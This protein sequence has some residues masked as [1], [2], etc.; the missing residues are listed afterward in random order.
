MENKLLSIF[1]EFQWID[2]EDLRKKCISTW[3]Q[4]IAE[5]GWNEESLLKLPF[6]MTELKDCPVLLVEHVKNVTKTAKEI[7]ELFIERYDIPQ[8]PQ[9]DV[10]I[11]GA[12]LHDVGKLIE[13]E[14]ADGQYRHCR[15]GD[16]IRHPLAGAIIAAQNGLPDEIIHIVG[17]HSFEGDHSYKT[18][19]SYIVKTSDWLNFNYLS[20]TYPN[21]MTH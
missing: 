13:Y 8:K 3:A 12:L 16:F 6:V 19:E 4:A 21:Q 15:K 10:V 2:D 17:T 7:V 11:A 5:G 1:P 14:Y 18:M 20:F 9:R